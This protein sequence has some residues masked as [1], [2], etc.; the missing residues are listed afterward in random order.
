MGGTYNNALYC[1]VLGTTPNNRSKKPFLNNGGHGPLMIPTATLESVLSPLIK[2]SGSLYLAHTVSEFEDVLNNFD[3]ASNYVEI[4][5][6]ELSSIDMCKTVRVGIVGVDNDLL[7]F[8]LI[9][10]TGNLASLG[11]PNFDAKSV[12]YICIASK[13]NQS[14]YEGATEPAV[15]GSTPSALE[16]KPQFLLNGGDEPA[17]FTDA[18]LST[19]LTDCVQVSKT[20]YLAKNATQLSTV[21]STLNSWTGRDYFL[22]DTVTTVDLGKTIRLG[23]VGGECDLITFASSKG[24]SF[25]GNG[26][27]LTSG[28]VVV[29]SKLGQDYN[30][31]LYPSVLGSAPR[32]S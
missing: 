5:S 4:E 27:Q 28:N 32:D 15:T 19:I 18:N 26:N 20:F 13:V 1:C 22:S 11:E 30:D 12:G 14:D 24:Q 7:V 29:A 16:V 3:N 8:R 2:V 31:A 23:I 9:K 6:H 10:R 25:L 21:C 17:I